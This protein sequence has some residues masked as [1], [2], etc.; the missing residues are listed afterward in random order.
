MTI[1]FDVYTPVY[2][3]RNAEILRLGLEADAERSANDA[4][5]FNLLVHRQAGAM[6]MLLINFDRSVIPPEFMSAYQ[7]HYSTI[8]NTR[9]SKRWV[10]EHLERGAITEEELKLI[11]IDIE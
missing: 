11:G 3:G 5:T 4:F 1:G 6:S 10:R 9:G 7:N 8:F 2:E